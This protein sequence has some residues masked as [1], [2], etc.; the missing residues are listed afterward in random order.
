MEDSGHTSDMH[1]VHSTQP[2]QHPLA[3]TVSTTTVLG[4][5]YVVLKDDPFTMAQTTT[6]NEDAGSMKG[7]KLL[8]PQASLDLE[9]IACTGN[10]NFSRKSMKQPCNRISSKIQ[11][12]K[13]KSPCSCSG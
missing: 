6:K 12:K 3:M 8:L 10:S 13:I 1:S 11:E 2:K 5:I 7:G 4:Y 9:W